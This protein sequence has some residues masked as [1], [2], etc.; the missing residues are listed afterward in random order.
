MTIGAGALFGMVGMILAAPLISA[1]VR[2]HDDRARIKA[3]REAE[4][5]GAARDVGLAADALKPA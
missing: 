2:I 4:E 3:S 5:S 1:A